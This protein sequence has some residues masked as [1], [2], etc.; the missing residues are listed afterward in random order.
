MFGRLFSKKNKKTKQ[1]AGV[2]VKLSDGAVVLGNAQHHGKRN[3]Q[4][5]SFGFSDISEDITYNKGILAVLADGIGGLSNG[6]DV[7]EATVSG[8]LNWFGSNAEAGCT[9]EDLKNAICG[10][11][12]NICEIFC[13]DGTINSGSTV[14]AANI[15][16]GYLH[17]FCVGDSRLYIKRD[18]KLFAVNEDTDYFNQLLNKVIAG[19]MAL[20][21][22]CSEPQKDS[23]AACIGNREFTVFDYSKKGFK[24]ND[25]D[26]LMLCSDGVY[27][28][29]PEEELCQCITSDAMI[30]CNDIIER[31]ISKRIPSQD[32]NTIIIMSYQKER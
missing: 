29:L 11:N 15:N 19:S 8:I 25:G 18:G 6:K 7:S 21:E 32:N 20:D 2:Y 23:L 5:D 13:A 30:A 28:A 27:N 9:G 16:N 10:I 17:W 12:E 3:Y 26:I 14:V 24:L 1:E 22:A 31:I 4:E